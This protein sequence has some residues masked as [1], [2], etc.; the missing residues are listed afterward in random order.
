MA[1]PVWRTRSARC[2]SMSC[3]WAL[4]RLT[5]PPS[6]Q[7]TRPHGA[8]R[9]PTASLPSSLSGFDGLRPRRRDARVE[10]WVAAVANGELVASH[11]ERRHGDAGVTR[12]EGGLADQVAVVEEPDGPGW[13]STGAGDGS[14]Q[15]DG[16]AGRRR[17]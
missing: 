1:R 12:V 11:R 13:R 2:S 14:D 15:G 17:A 4:V 7:D 3:P 6:W 16:L 5:Q 9:Q 8:A 10:R